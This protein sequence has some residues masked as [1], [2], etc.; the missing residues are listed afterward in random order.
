MRK[1]VQIMLAVGDEHG[2]PTGWVEK[3]CFDGLDG[4][5]A[6]ELSYPFWPPSCSPVC[7]HIPGEKVIKFSR[8]KFHIEGYHTWVGNW[9]WDAVSCAP[10]VATAL[11]NYAL[12]I[13]FT[14]EGGWESIYRKIEAKEPIISRD[15]CA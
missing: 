10:E 8:R 5:T 2:N 3:I 11:A 13:G 14:P 12:K 4:D 7:Y 6:L 1:L 15:W 9:C